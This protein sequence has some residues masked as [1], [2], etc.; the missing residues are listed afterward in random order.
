MVSESTQHIPFRTWLRRIF[1]GALIITYIPLVVV[2]VQIAVIP[3]KYLLITLPLYGVLVAAVVYML[4]AGKKLSTH[5]VRLVLVLLLSVCLSAANVAGV[6]AIRSADNLLSGIQSRQESYV[7]YVVIS[8]KE[9]Q[10][11]VATAANV[12]TVQ[13]DPLFAQASEELTHETPA[14]QQSYATLTDLAEGMRGDQVILGSMRAASW[15][16]LEDNYKEF[17][18]EMTVLATYRVR[19]SEVARP[20]ADITKPFVLYISG[21]DTYG[22]VSVV[23]RSDVNMLAAVN[24]KTNSILLVNTPRDYYVQLHGTTGTPDKLTHAGTYGIDMSRQTLEDVYQTQIP[25]YARINF[26]SLVKIIDTI[27]PIEVYSDYTF[28]SYHEGYNTLDSKHAL[29]FARERYSFEDGDRQR[30]RNQQRVIEAI[31][32]KM[33]KPQNAVHMNEVLAA[34]KG[35]LDTNVG[36]QAIKQFIRAQLNDVKA[37]RVESISVDGTGAM[38]PTYSMGAQPLY[39]MIPDELSLAE[40]RQRIANTLQ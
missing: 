38:L 19:A 9:A 4:L 36:E 26:T 12:G 11:Q 30:G 37:W 13:T 2:F 5:R 25:Y 39:V 18:D 21:I 23:S 1:A 35:S 29:E 10:V 31:I 20:Q 28:K 17:Y 33:N 6:M 16:L 14:Q 15:H 22:D 3:S 40:A 7:E 32:A 27:G 24:P 34:V 8:K